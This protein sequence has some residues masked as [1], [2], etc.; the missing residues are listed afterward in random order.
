V[1]PDAAR[2][3]PRLPPLC[4]VSSAQDPAGADDGGSDE[5][6]EED[7][8]EDIVDRETLKKQSLSILDKVAKKTKK[9]KPKKG[10]E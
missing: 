8:E 9:R 2:R 7:L 1:Y 6:F 3:S 5:E 10:G 4:V